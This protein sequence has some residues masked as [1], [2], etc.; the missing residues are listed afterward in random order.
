MAKNDTPTDR[1]SHVAEAL[2][3][4]AP[5]SV[6]L[7]K[8]R[9]ISMLP[10]APEGS[11]PGFRNIRSLRD[12]VTGAI[13]TRIV[14][15]ID[16]QTDAM[17]LENYIPGIEVSAGRKLQNPDNP[18][19]EFDD[20]TDP[21]N[22]RFF[23]WRLNIYDRVIAT[24]FREIDMRPDKNVGIIGIN[25]G[26][27]I[28]MESNEAGMLVPKGQIQD[29]F[30][31]HVEV[32]HPDCVCQS[33][34]FPRSKTTSDAAES[35][36][37]DSS[38]LEIDFIADIA[39]AM[40]CIWNDLTE[41]EKHQFAGF[42]ITVGT[43]TCVEAMTIL[44]TML[45]P[46][47]PFS[48]V[49]IGAMKPM[50]ETGS[51]GLENFKSAYDDLLSL[52]E[53][54]LTTFGLRVEGGLY[55]PTKTRKISDKLHT[56]FQGEKLIDSTKNETAK[57]AS[58]ANFRATK[59]EDF[60]QPYLETKAFRGTD[61]VLFIK[62]TISKDPFRLTHEVMESDTQAILVETYPSLTQAMKDMQAIL[63][64]ANGRPIF[65]VNQVLGGSVDQDYEVAH[66]L[67]EHGINVLD[68]TAETARAKINLALRLFGKDSQKI[69]DV[70]T[71]TGV[72]ALKSSVQ[73]AA[74]D[75]F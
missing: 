49:A 7:A 28:M 75:V 53:R 32:D 74:L 59:N 61:D 48:V 17:I 73:S 21:E 1:P 18:G 68:M 2:Q 62:S 13:S 64:G 35:Y 41:K 45:G 33:F 46:N 55:D 66:R 15:W 27:T 70:V 30:K 23:T 43:D 6:M 25:L 72:Q 22:L 31:Q 14:P 9:F 47:C 4:A 37:I 38:Q 5:T 54:G 8:S 36:G 51:D 19:Y 58:A 3:V 63:R 29:K 11:T 50:E 12:P 34:A 26:G 16:P 40:T 20:P 56:S 39:I 10:P 71:G 44:K 67:K 60:A 69:I 24:V 42:V 65:Y 57:T 52:R